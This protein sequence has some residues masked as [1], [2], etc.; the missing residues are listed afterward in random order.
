M[1]TN[2]LGYNNNYTSHTG[3]RKQQWKQQS[4]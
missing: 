2:K 4:A 3:H 1:Q